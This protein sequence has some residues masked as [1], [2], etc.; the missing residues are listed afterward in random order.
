MLLSPFCS[1]LN[2][3]METKK[4]PVNMHEIMFKANKHL[5][6]LKLQKGAVDC[7]A[8]MI[9]EAASRSKESFVSQQKD[10]GPHPDS[11]LTSL[12]QQS[13]SSFSD[14]LPLIVRLSMPP[15]S[16]LNELVSALPQQSLNVA[17]DNKSTGKALEEQILKFRHRLVECIAIS[18]QASSENGYYYIAECA[19][20]PLLQSL[21]AK[22]VPPSLLASYCQVCCSKFGVWQ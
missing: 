16:L 12:L 6:T 5:E 3:R 9:K 15:F 20:R 21:L 22:N 2:L 18:S 13:L 17:E 1:Y 14:L 8:I 4:V 7:L 11:L 10:L 19:L